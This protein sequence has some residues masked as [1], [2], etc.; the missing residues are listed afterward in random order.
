MRALPEAAA[1]YGRLSPED[2]DRLHALEAVVQVQMG[3]ERHWLRCQPRPVSV[4]EFLD[5]A[6]RLGL[7]GEAGAPSLPGAGVA[8]LRQVIARREAAFAPTLAALGSA[9]AE[10]ESAEAPHRLLLI[11]GADE[12][13]AARLFQVTAEEVESRCEEVL[14]MG[15]AAEEVAQVFARRGRI[16]PRLGA[17]AMQGLQQA[18]GRGGV[19]AV[20]ATRYAEAVIAGRPGE[21]FTHRL[22]AGELARLLALH[23]VAGRGTALGDSLQLMIR[24]RE[25]GPEG[26]LPLSHRWTRPHAADLVQ[27]HLLR[28]WM[29]GAGSAERRR[30]HG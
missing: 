21:A 18:T 29:A 2:L 25:A 30:A 20:D 28:L 4:P 23:A 26:F 8:M 15:T 6:C 13:T 5:A 16:T 9:S 14:V 12:L 22:D 27:D 7:P 3:E 19:I 11:L 1:A 17:E 24:L 10:P